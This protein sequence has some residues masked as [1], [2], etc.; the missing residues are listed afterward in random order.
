MNN[1]KTVDGTV[2]ERGRLTNP[3]QLEGGQQENIFP[4]AFIDPVKKIPAE[5]H[6]PKLRRF[7]I[8]LT[9]QFTTGL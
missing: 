1:K 8:G 5:R 3:G 2:C 6:V 4:P 9:L 7:L